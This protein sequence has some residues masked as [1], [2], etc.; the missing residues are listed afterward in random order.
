MQPVVLIWCI[1][2]VAVVAATLF[3]AIFVVRL[4][5]HNLSQKVAKKMAVLRPLF[6]RVVFGDATLDE[7]SEAVGSDQAIAEIIVLDILREITGEGR[8]NVINAAKRIGLIDR[9]AHLLNHV[10]WA[11][12]D[13]AAM[14]LGI[15]R[16]PDTVP[17]LVKRLHDRRVE[18]RYTAGRSL[19]M[20]DSPEAA[21]ALVAIF[22]QPHLLDT[23]RVLEI[24]QNMENRMSG[25]LRQLLSPENHNEAVKLLAIDLIGDLQDNSLADVLRALLSSNDREQVVRALK[26]LGKLSIPRFSEQIIALG[27]DSAWEIR[28]Q[29]CKTIGLLKLEEGLELLTKLLGDE[30]FWVRRNAAEALVAFGDAGY[31]AL[32]GQRAHPDVFARDLVYYHLEM[33]EPGTN[34]HPQEAEVPA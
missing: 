4:F 29:A 12:R 22:D 20:I 16:V 5:D 32:V 18:V 9:N 15:Y 30:A 31:D 11:H 28:A 19:G 14:K 7:V 26:A 6:T 24:V 34:G 17:A 3:F 1:I 25:P 10:D 33:L 8:E 27:Q 13:I 2:V 21:E 23:P